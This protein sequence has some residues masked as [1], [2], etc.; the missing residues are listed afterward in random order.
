MKKFVDVKARRAE[1][2]GILKSL[3]FVGIISAV[4]IV[5]VFYISNMGSEQGIKLTR[6]A[7]VRTAVECYAIEGI[8]PPNV[9][10]MEDN[11]NLS[12]D[13]TKYYIHYDIFASNIMPTIEVYEKR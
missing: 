2:Q 13:K 11:Y 12:Y 4:L 7:A 1:R 10:Y 8:Y 9:Q 5:G 6:E 3:L